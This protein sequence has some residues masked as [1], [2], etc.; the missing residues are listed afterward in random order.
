[1][2][3]DVSTDV[4]LIHAAIGDS[5]GRWF[6]GLAAPLVRTRWRS[7]SGYTGIDR[8]TYGTIR[9]LAGTSTAPRDDL[10]TVYLPATFAAPNPVAVETLHGD[11]R[12]RYAELGLNFYGDSEIDAD[13]VLDRLDAA[14]AWI[15]R[16]PGAATA[17]GSV[18]AALH[19]A[20][21]E[22]SDYDV[23]YSDPVLPFSIFVGISASPRAN[24][25]LRLAEGILHECMHLQLT[26]IE[27]TVPLVS[28]ADERHHSPWQRVLRP[29]Q[30]V[31][32]GL[33]VFRVIQDFH[34]A[35]LDSDSLVLSE[36]THIR[37][38][39]AQIEEE[40]ATVSDLAESRDLTATGRGLAAALLAH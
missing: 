16:V 1:M 2:P 17:V 27:E 36:R 24:G 13:L 18:L 38:R 37:Q 8:S 40:V 22:G 25:D 21:P 31:L 15:A 20:R 29:S 19:I 4:D 12:N 39:I 28:G 35:I 33:Y 23:S 5:A 9:Y 11:V 34:R 32:H 7:V 26:L 14:F 3:A 30:G 6:S 10:A